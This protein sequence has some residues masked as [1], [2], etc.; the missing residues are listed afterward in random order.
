MRTNRAL[1]PLPDPILFRWLVSASPLDH[2]VNRRNRANQGAGDSCEPPPAA[3]TVEDNPLFGTPG[4][5]FKRSFADDLL[6]CKSS[7]SKWA[8]RDPPR[9]T[10]ILTNP[11]P[12]L[13]CKVS[14]EGGYGAGG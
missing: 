2:D 12:F 10:S 8:T 9:R 1:A 14:P 3:M 11:S 4:H 13:R 6:I 5:L 7:P